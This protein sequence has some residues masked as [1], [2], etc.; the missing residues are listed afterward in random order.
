[1]LLGE[2]HDR[3]IEIEKVGFVLHG[4]ERARIVRKRPQVLLLEPEFCNTIE[5]LALR[6]RVPG[7]Q[8]LLQLTSERMH[9]PIAFDAGNVLPEGRMGLKPIFLECFD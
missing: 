6:R 7:R 1:M 4:C 2:E 5:M 3:A 9:L 8:Y